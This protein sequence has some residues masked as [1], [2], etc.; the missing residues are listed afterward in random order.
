MI[1]VIEAWAK[2]AIKAISNKPSRWSAQGA[3]PSMST[4]QALIMGGMSGGRWLTLIDVFTANATISA[5]RAK[6]P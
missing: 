4:P 6:I 3:T 1:G 5:Q 2:A